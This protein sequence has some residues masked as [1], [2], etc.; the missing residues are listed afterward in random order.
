VWSGLSHNVTSKIIVVLFKHK[1]FWKLP[2]RRD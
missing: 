2:L 1:L